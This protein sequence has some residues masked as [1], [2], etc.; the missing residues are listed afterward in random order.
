MLQLLRTIFV[1]HLDI[2][3]E[4]FSRARAEGLTIIRPPDAIKPEKPWIVLATA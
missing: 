3:V 1:T 2:N 4:I